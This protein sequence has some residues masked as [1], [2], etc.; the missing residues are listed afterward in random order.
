MILIQGFC[1]VCGG[2]TLVA[3]PTSEK[4]KLECSNVNCPN[5]TAA[6]IIL[7]DDEVDHIVD[8]EEKGFT[9]RHP[10]RERIDD[11]LLNCS[12]HNY[13]LEFAPNYLGFDYEVGKFRVGNNGASGEDFEYTF[14]KLGTLPA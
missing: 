13:L 6:A 1:P 7:N 2:A 11:Q 5:P 4:A 12:L 9:M 14:E 10:L 8:F 3:V